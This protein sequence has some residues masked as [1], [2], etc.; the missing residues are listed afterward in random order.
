MKSFSVLVLKD[1]QMMARRRGGVLSALGVGAIVMLMASVAG[2]ATPEGLA[3]RGA[4][5]FWLGVFLGSTLLLSDAFDAEQRNGAQ[6]S[7][8]LLG[9]SPTAFFYAKAVANFLGLLIVGAALT[10]IAVALFG[11][12]LDPFGGG[13]LL[14]IGTMSLAAPGTLFTGLVAESERRNLLLP[15]LVFP[16]VLPVLI[17]VVQT[18]LLLVFGDP[19]EQGKAWMALL[20]VFAL[21]HWIL[22]GALYA[23]GVD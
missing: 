6:R 5:A 12:S 17:G 19:M 3:R 7:L 8:V 20:G 22:D 4:Q 11:V 2:D 10:P 18:T 15:I 21:L 14:T 16:L 23:K 13:A 1:L 9:A